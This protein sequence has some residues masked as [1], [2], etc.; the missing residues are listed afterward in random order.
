LFVWSCVDIDKFNN[1]VFPPQ[2]I[3]DQFDN[4]RNVKSVLTIFL[5]SIEKSMV[6]KDSIF[7]KITEIKSFHS[8]GRNLLHF[9]NFN[10][11]RTIRINS[12]S[13]DLLDLIGTIVLIG[14]LEQI[15]KD[16]DIIKI[17]I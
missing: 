13:K 2:S 16:K 1:W 4:D 15:R 8:F 11:I 5:N 9:N 12:Q 14:D 7:R 10:S 6:I 3:I 17:L